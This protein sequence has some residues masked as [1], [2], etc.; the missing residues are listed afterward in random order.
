M[1]FRSERALRVRA[2]R[3]E[4]ISAATHGRLF[5]LPADESALASPPALP[6]HFVVS[7]NRDLVAANKAVAYDEAQLQH[8]RLEGE[9]IVSYRA[10]GGWVAVTKDA[11]TEV[12]GAGRDAHIAGLPRAAARVARLM[13]RDLAVLSERAH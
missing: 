11:L 8:S 2:D 12:L 6:A 5:L 3:D 13:C 1:L 4:T 10:P 9:F 7:T